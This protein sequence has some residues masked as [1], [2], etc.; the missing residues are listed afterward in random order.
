MGRWNLCHLGEAHRRPRPGRRPLAIMEEALRGRRSG[1]A[2]G[3]P[4]VRAPAG[5]R[6]GRG[7]AGEHG[8]PA[9]A[10]RGHTPVSAGRKVDGRLPRRREPPIVPSGRQK[11]NLRLHDPIRDGWPMDPATERRE[12]M[13]PDPT[14][15]L[16]RSAQPVPAR[17]AGA[18]RN[19]R[20]PR[21]NRRD[22]HRLG[23]A[24]AGGFRCPPDPPMPRLRR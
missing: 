23:G 14:S 24:H 10:A 3:S 16:S 20:P 7:G 15:R 19:R 12:S 5:D 8:A 1:W 13:R 9:R 11:S 17:R 6:R 21:A 4:D 22:R 18:C 2:T